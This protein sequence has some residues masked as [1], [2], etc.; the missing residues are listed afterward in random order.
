MG[1]GSMFT[2]SEQMFCWGSAR[3]VFHGWLCA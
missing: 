2:L 3:A 1:D